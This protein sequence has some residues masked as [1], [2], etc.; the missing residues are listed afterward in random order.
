MFTDATDAKV[1][2]LAG[3]ATLT[4]TS[5]KTGARYTYKINQLKDRESGEMKPLWFV[6]LLSGPDN[7]S[8]YTYMGT[9]G[10]THEFR[11]TAK[12]AYKADSLPVRGFQF[13][14]KHVIAGQMAPM[15]Q[16]EHSGNCGRCGRLLTVPS[17]IQ[18]GLG[19]ECASKMGG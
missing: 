8:D 16:V 7:T 15:L 9:I 19:P 18:S 1:Y 14:W 10:A 4:L 5:E 17:S 6:A 12:S 3:H 2:A 11:L 13:F